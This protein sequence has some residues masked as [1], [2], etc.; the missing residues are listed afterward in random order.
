MH[1]YWEIRVYRTWKDT[2]QL[3]NGEET[4]LQDTVSFHLENR[5]QYEKFVQIKLMG[6]KIV[7]R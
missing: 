3:V 2:L 4:S 6:Y 1:I 7:E 5:Y